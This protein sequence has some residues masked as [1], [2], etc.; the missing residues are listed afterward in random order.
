L[1]GRRAIVAA[2]ITVAGIGAIALV[3][4]L[5][6]WDTHAPGPE[7]Y[8]LSTDSRQITEGRSVLG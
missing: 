1:E 6:M 2:A 3:S 8:E 4:Y 5:S 7:A